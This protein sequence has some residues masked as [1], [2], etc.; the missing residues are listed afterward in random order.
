MN[1]EDDRATIDR[2]AKRGSPA[3]PF[4]FIIDPVTEL[5]NVMPA[6]AREVVY[7]REALHNLRLEFEDQIPPTSEID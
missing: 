6:L 5:L 3:G 1:T 4:E 7:L 2:W